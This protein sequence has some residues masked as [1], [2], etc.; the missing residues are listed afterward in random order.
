[1]ESTQQKQTEQ[2]AIS[3]ASSSSSDEGRPSK[4]FIDLKAIAKEV[5]EGN[6]MYA[7]TTIKDYFGYA[8]VLH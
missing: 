1:M 5:R 4:E 7:Q 2:Q 3:S 6:P 8:Y